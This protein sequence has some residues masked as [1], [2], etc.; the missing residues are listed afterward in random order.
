MTVDVLSAAVAGTQTEIDAC[1]KLIREK[2]PI[3][4]F[5]AM[6]L[7]QLNRPTEQTLAV[8]DSQQVRSDDWVK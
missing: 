2:F 5:P 8:P 1:L 3:K 6:T 4:K 7:Q